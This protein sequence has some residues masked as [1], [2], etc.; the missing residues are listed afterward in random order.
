VVGG[1]VGFSPTKRIGPDAPLCPVSS[2]SKQEVDATDVSNAGAA[3][4]LLVAE[5]AHK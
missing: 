5:S 1:P 4:L 2:G 3:V